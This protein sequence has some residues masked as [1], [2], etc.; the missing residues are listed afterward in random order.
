MNKEENIE[1]KIVRREIFTSFPF[2]SLINT[3]V[4]GLPQAS[5]INVLFNSPSSTIFV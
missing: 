3:L 1:I 2:G 4:P 5:E